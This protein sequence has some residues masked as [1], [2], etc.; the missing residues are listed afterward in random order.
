MTEWNDWMRCLNKMNES[1]WMNEM[2][3]QD[4]WIRLLN[5]MDDWDWLLR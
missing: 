5:E 3:E 2:I 1:R 4:D